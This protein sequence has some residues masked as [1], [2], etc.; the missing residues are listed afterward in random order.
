[1]TNEERI[2][3]EINSQNKL[4]EAIKADAEKQLAAQLSAARQAL[5]IEDLKNQQM[6]AGVELTFEKENQLR[7]E[8]L[9][10]EYE[11]SLLSIQGTENEAQQKALIEQKY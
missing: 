1:M 11:Y 6:Y 10:K 5:D 4:N 7:L 2:L 3:D 8:R 9:Q